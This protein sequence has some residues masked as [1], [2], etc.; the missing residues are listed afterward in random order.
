MVFAASCTCFLILP[1][2]MLLLPLLF[3][4][5]LSDTSFYV[6]HNFSEYLSPVMVYS[7]NYQYNSILK[8]PSNIFICGCL[9]LYIAWIKIRIFV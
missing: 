3:Q 5:E 7:I 1:T 2:F 6:F 8:F 9:F 4:S